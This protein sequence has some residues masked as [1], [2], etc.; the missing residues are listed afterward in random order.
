MIRLKLLVVM[1][2]CISAIIPI[3]SGIV[4]SPVCTDPGDQSYPV[5][6]GDTIVWEENGDIYMRDMASEDGKQPV[7]TDP[8]FQ[9]FPDISGDT[10]VWVDTRGAES[11]D[12]YMADLSVAPVA[13]VSDAGPDQVVQIG[14]TVTFNGSDSSDLD[15]SVV[16]YT[17]EFG[18]GSTSTDM[19]ATHMYTLSGTYTA[20][21]TVTDNDGLTDT[22]SARITVQ[23]PQEG[24]DDLIMEVS[25]LG[26]P[27]GIENGLTAKLYAAIKS[28]NKGNDG[29]AVNQIHAFINQVHA[30]VGKSLTEEEADFLVSEAQNII[31]AIGV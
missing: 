7:C 31:A 13:P 19:I 16:S 23:T 15:G 21:L 10:V 25:T 8:S 20:T 22:D 4:I 24:L 26:L 28:C 17:W 12:I 11:K 5:I 6:S 30:K 27:A 2:L 29:A 14:E 1:I 18:D 3:T 9:G